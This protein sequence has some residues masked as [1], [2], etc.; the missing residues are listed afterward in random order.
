MCTLI[1]GRDVLGERTVILAAN[2]DE[3]PRRP[4]DPPG[5]LSERPRVIGGRDRLAGGTWLA[6]RERRALVAMLNRRDRSGEPA[7]R[8]EDRRSRG[9]LTIDV[10]KVPNPG[11]GLGSGGTAVVAIAHHADLSRLALDQAVEAAARERYAP[12]S[13][14]FASSES[15]WWLAHEGN[16]TP[17]EV[18]V[19]EGWHV[20]THMDLDDLR[21]PRTSWLKRELEGFR[22][23]SLDEALT[24]LGEL[25]RSHGSSGPN[26]PAPPVCLHEGRMVTVSSSLVWLAEGEARYLHAEGR[27]CENRFVDHS[28]LLAGGVP[29]AGNR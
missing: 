24:R 9:L 19:P 16:G 10:A 7:A 28:H 14:V 22:P 2:R 23:R 3:D 8:A 21:E 5:V 4:S 12:F 11:A 15:C 27:P 13:M 20:L 25:L 18:N 29:A 26:D 1:I 17:R 6:V